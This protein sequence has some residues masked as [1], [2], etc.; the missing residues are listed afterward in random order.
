[1][2]R[3][4]RKGP[5]KKDN[6]YFGGR[7]RARNSNDTSRGDQEKSLVFQMLAPDTIGVTFQHFFDSDLKDIIKPLASG[8]Y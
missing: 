2:L 3:L 4:L 8:G 5:A 1:M 6:T 7:G